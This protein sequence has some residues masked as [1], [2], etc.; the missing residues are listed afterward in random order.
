MAGVPAGK[1]F[2]SAYF[3]YDVIGGNLDQQHDP[4]RLGVGKS[5]TSIGTRIHYVILAVVFVSLLPAGISAWRARR[6]S[7]N[8]PAAGGPIV[9]PQ[10]ERD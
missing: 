8:P 4:G 5:V 10:V 7:K 2:T 9:S 6:G 3:T 1:T